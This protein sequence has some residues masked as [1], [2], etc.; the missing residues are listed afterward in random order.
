M[1]DQYAGDISDVIKFALL[2]ALSGT[3]RTLGIAWYY[4]PGHDGR[5]D[6]K[7]MEWRD[8][9]AWQKL[10]VELHLGL[11]SLPERSIA[12]LERAA[13]WPPGTRFHREPVPFD[14]ERAAWAT[15]KRDSLDG[16]SIVFA[17][18]DNG[19]GK[20][21]KHATF[22]EIKRLRQPGRAV[23][24]ITFPHQGVKH[25]VQLKRLHE[26]LKADADATNLATLRTCISVPRGDGSPYRIPRTR[27][28]T[29]IDGD[30]ELIGRARALADRLSAIPH[31]KAQL[32]YDE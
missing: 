21:E 30:S 7:H 31:V 25:E 14:F 10:D 1:R 22:D 11:S 20:T 23:V 5:P 13:I 26:R 3:D 28:F 9:P 16:A 8:E 4:A 24:F 27:W 19:M 12:A 32:S 17:D 29:I 6:G 2:R 18:P 15:R